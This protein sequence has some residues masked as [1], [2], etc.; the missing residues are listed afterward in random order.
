MTEQTETIMVELDLRD[1]AMAV[2]IIDLAAERGGF[3]GPEMQVL[4]EYRGRL[5]ELVQRNTPAQPEEAQ[6]A[7]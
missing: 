7:E 1:V 2:Q 5:A 3:R 6:G 4:G